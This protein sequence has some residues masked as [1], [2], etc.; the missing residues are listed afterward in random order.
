MM[1]GDA[2]AFVGAERERAADAFCGNASVFVSREGKTN[3]WRL[4][5]AYLV[6]HFV[7]LCVCV[8]ACGR[9]ESERGGL[10]VRKLSGDFKISWNIFP[11]N[12][13]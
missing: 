5:N 1:K 11:K 2:E 6:A 4:P 8:R 7:R 12:A 9:F 13:V 10:Q 3:K